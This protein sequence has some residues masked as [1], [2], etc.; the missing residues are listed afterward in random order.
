VSIPSPLCVFITAGP[1]TKLFAGEESGRVL[2]RAGFPLVESLH[3][4]KPAIRP[5]LWSIMEPERSLQGS[6]Q[7]APDTVPGGFVHWPVPEHGPAAAHTSYAFH[8][9]YDWDAYACAYGCVH[10]CH[11]HAAVHCAVCARASGRPCA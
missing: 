8:D 6:P 10:V 1:I 9:G 3:E 4:P 11:G 7:G 2:V 5:C